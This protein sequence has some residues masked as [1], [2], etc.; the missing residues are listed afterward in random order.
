VVRHT[1]KAPRP[2]EEEWTGGIAGEEDGTLDGFF[3]FF[4]PPPTFARTGWAR[5]LM[6]LINV[7]Y[8]CFGFFA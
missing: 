3:G 5:D 6:N 7:L 1:S 2:P 8:I 4:L